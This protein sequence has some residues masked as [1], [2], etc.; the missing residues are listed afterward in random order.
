[1]VGSR[2]FDA[3]NVGYVTDSSPFSNATFQTDPSNTNGNGNNGHNYGT[4]LSEDDR[5]ALIEY[6]KTF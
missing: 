2:V 4:S 6:L 1:M 5:W 3:K